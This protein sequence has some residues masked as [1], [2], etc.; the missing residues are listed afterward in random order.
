MTPPSAPSTLQWMNRPK[1]RSRNHSSRSGRLREPFSTCA[2]TDAGT[3][4]SSASTAS[5][6]LMLHK[7]DLLQGEDRAGEARA[8]HAAIGGLEPD[9]SAHVGDRD[10]AVVRAQ[11]EP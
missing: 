8:G 10:A 11:G 3:A 7:P 5:A 2:G 1:P 9:L 4:T 6:R